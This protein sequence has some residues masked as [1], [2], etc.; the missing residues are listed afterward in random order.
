[1]SSLVANE[2]LIKKVW[3]PR[4]VLPVSN[5]ASIGV[6]WLLE[7]LVLVLTLLLFGG[8]PLVWVPL[9]LVF[10]VVLAVFA[11][12]VGLALSVFNVYFRDTQYLMT[13]VLQAW[14]YAT[15]VVY[16]TYLVQ[17]QSDK[18]GPVLGD[19]TVWDLYRVNPMEQ[20][21]EVFRNL[22]YDNRLPALGTVLTVL[23][24]TVGSLLVGSWVFSR[25]EKRLA[26]ML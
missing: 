10:M 11:T 2:N 15:P 13:I 21:V 19:V 25:H 5:A 9:T 24:W 1:M 17:E 8:A 26:E 20:F 18:I 14:F 3:F 23:A 16:P 12:G 4:A 22:L 6:S 7:M